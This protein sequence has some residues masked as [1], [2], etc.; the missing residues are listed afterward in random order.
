M[1]SRA[2]H[3]MQIGQ[4][5]IAWNSLHENLFLLF[6]M[7]T[8]NGKKALAHG[9]WHSVASDSA[10]RGFLR[11]A[12][13]AQ[14]SKRL[15]AAI[16]WIV[17]QADKIGADRN[18]LIHSPMT[19]T[20]S[21][22]GKLILTPSALGGKTTHIERL[23]SKPSPKDWDIVRGNLW[24]LAQYAQAIDIHL[25][26]QATEIPRAW[27]HRPRLLRLEGAVKPRPRPKTHKPKE[28]VRQPSASRK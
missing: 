10:Q 5:S 15:F 24:V 23:R 27:P 3:A 17:K 16:D 8:G 28:P 18:A 21:P 9:I 11:A 4:V 7:L 20:A 6:W 25:L 2:A 22:Q 14:K 19:T 26:T 13:Q 1:E 12:A